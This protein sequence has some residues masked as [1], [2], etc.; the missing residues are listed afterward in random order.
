M[1]PVKILSKQNITASVIHRWELVEHQEDNLHQEGSLSQK[2][3]FFH[4]RS[5]H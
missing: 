5:V 1:M 3:N 4:K 2:G